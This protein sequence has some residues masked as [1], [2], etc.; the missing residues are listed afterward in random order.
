[1]IVIVNYG[2][3]NLGSIFN[4]LKRVGAEATIS[5]NLTDIELADKLILPGVGSFEKGMNNL[6]ENGFIPVLNKKVLQEKIP[7][8][9]IC[10]GMQLLSKR[11]EE[12]EKCDGLD[13][14]DAETVK[15][16]FDGQSENM[17]IPHMGWNSIR[18]QKNSPLFYELEE[19][20]RFYFVH[21]YHVK[22]RYKEDIIAKT[23]Y[24]SDFVSSIEHENVLGTQFHPE[25][26]HKFGMKLMK[27]F[28]EYY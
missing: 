27:N 28:V 16:N 5:S 14:L 24:G 1:M 25:K 12:G 11:S 21:S 2:L 22:C 17:K 23:T 13:W 26:S 20:A 3:G 10:L 8:L 6:R 9:G 19:Q 15:F 18:R 7:I 4:M